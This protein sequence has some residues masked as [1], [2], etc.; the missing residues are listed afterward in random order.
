MGN[1]AFWPLAASSLKPALFGWSASSLRP[2]RQHAAY[3]A[4]LCQTHLPTVTATGDKQATSATTSRRLLEP[5][6]A[7]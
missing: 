3:A 5:Q 7:G 2:D 4:L 1:D 6:G